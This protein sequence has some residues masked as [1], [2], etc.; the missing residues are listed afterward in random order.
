MT[1]Q[2]KLQT[3]FVTGASGYIGGRLVPRLLAAGYKVRVL[4]RSPEKLNDRSWA[5]HPD[6]KIFRGDILDIESLRQAISGCRAAY[7]LV[8]SMNPGVKD[9]AR[10]DRIAAQNMVSAA[11]EAS[12]RQI[13]YL[14]G[15]GNNSVDLSHHMQSRL[16]VG[17]ILQQ[18]NVPVTIL[19]AAMIIG[20]GSA[21]FEILRYLVDRLPLMITPR[22]I[23]TPCQP[24]AVRDVLRDLIGCLFNPATLGQT[25]DI[26]QPKI[27]SYR[28]LMEIYAEEA[29][30]PQR[31]IFTVPVSTPRL[32]SYWIHLAT[33]VPAAIARPL[34]EGL[35]I[36]VS[37]RENRLDTIIPY[38]RLD[39]REA[40]RLALDRM[41]Q[42]QVETSWTDS[43]K[44]AA[45]EWSLPDDPNRASG[46]L[47]EDSRRIIVAASRQHTWPAVQSIGGDSGYY[48]ADSLWKVRG[49]IDRL[50]GG[51]GLCRGRRKSQE[52][53]PG[54]AIDFWR[55]ID[56]QKEEYLLLVAEMKLPGKA[57][58]LF[59][60]R[61]L[62]NDRTE[63]QQVARFLPQGLPGIL[64][65]Y[66]VMPFHHFVFNGMLRG[67]AKAT[68]VKV[69]KGPECVHE[70]PGHKGEERIP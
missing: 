56:V 9:F 41:G 35:S 6:L 64:Y 48:Y 20:S 33:P 3:V 1:Q 42:Q 28:Q 55:V 39:A 49:L 34:T 11:T 25:F 22:W 26:S 65:W 47:F 4:A 63:L 18:G 51:V 50:C 66:A 24:I 70:D 16:E 54:D 13:I 31:R 67:I 12:I 30:L 36:P 61:S 32:S 21:S 15:H 60:L 27:T 23:D 38:Q 14:G 17:A 62:D 19:Q 40:I 43:G 2:E 57:T 44:I 58:L 46:N 53:F 59:R 29:G 10:T 45:A 68:G 7:Y 8:H 69:V 37:W 5:S 52:L